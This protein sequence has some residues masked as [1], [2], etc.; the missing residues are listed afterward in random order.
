MAARIVYSDLDGTMVGP[1]GCFFLSEDKRLVLDPAQAL[2][3]LLAAGVTLVLVSGRTRPQLVEACRIFGADGYIGE[4]GSVIGWDQGREHEVLRGAMPAP[5]VGTPAQVVEASGVVPRLFDRYR[6]RLEYHSPWHVGHEGDVMLRGLIDVADAEAWL[7][8][9]GFAWL[10]ISDNGVLPPRRP[11]RLDP[12]AI[13]AHVYHL[14]PGGLSKGLAVQR[15]LQRR[16][17]PRD[18]AVAIGDSAS[19]LTMAPY[20][21][22]LWLTANG[23]RHEHMSELLAA[24][25]NVVICEEAV[26]LGWAHAVRDALR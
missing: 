1:G 8:A 5:Y 15:D 4:L 26:G 14:M 6:G 23:A 3:D 7:A 2:V 24:H 11:T 18:A 19:D 9:E 17:L 10:R 22:R 13:P 21:D 12:V 25:D 16:G 20:V